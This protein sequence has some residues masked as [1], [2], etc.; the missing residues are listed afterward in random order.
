MLYIFEFCSL[1]CPIFRYS[2]YWCI[3]QLM[4]TFLY[5]TLF[6]LVINALVYILIFFYTSFTSCVNTIAGCP[7]FPPLLLVMY[8]DILQRSSLIFP[9]QPLT[10]H[11]SN[12][13]IF[14]THFCLFSLRI[15]SKNLP[16]QPGFLL[17]FVSPSQTVWF[18]GA[19]GSLLSAFVSNMTG[20]T[21]LITSW[22]WKTD[23]LEVLIV[24]RRL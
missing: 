1:S 23:V 5:Q 13:V 19:E 6:P 4:L 22:I 7:S 10:F 18:Q 8:A 20:I 24:F 21:K 11:D 2:F 12:F 16:K 9:Y 14:S 3:W 15:T 17:G